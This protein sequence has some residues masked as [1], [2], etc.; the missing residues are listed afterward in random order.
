MQP[1]EMDALAGRAERMISAL[2]D[3]IM[4]TAEVA[5]E[6]IELA[7]QVAQVRQRVAAYAA[8]LEAIGSQKAAIAAQLETATGPMRSLLIKQVDIL[9]Q[10]E[11]SILE[12][13]GIPAET[14]QT[15][16]ESA[17]ALEARDDRKYIRDG[18]RFAPLNGR[19]VCSR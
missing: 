19:G 17:D 18:R 8:V 11:L 14:A 9:G 15:A 12:R 6:R 4:R 10:Q 13:I 7:S 2:S 3:A 5:A 16:I 1:N